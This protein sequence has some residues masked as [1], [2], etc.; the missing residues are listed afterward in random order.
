MDVYLKLFIKPKNETEESGPDPKNRARLNLNADVANGNV[1]M[2]W[3]RA[4]WHPTGRES[5][6]HYWLP[7]PFLTALRGPGSETIALC[8]T[9][10]PSSR[11]H[12]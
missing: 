7:L 11:I 8:Q 6:T 9:V 10:T 4:G 12:K 5:T 2:G 3:N 1:G